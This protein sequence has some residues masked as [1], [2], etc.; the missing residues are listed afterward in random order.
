MYIQLIFI[1][2]TALKWSTTCSALKHRL[3]R[4][5]VLFLGMILCPVILCSCRPADTDTKPEKNPALVLYCGAGIRPMADA[6]IDAFEQQSGIH[7]MATYAGSGRL[8]GQV[9][10]SR[11]GDLFMPGAASYVDQAVFLT[12]AVASTR[13]TVA[14]FIPVL[15]VQ[16]G[17]PVD[18]KTLADLTRP[19]LRVG[20]GDPRVCAVGRVSQKIF[21]KNNVPSDALASN[22]VFTSGTVTELGVALAM[23][24]ID[25]T[26]IWDATARQFPDGLDTIS[27]PAEENC[28]ATVP[29]IRLSF[30]KQPD[31]ADAFIA[32]ITSAEGK[33]IIRQQGYS[34]PE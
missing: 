26:V 7:V 24:T 16:K 1:M 15:C 12:A 18:I 4:T 5:V 29:V 22:T 17:N 13:T 28:I 10:S 11:Q 31:A 9:I 19:G 20:L 2:M 25:A 27:I 6:L 23:N 30:S 21:E 14:C 32:F 33:T 34:V 3:D 8:L